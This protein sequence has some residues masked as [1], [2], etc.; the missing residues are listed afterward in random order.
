MLIGLYCL[1]Y[2]PRACT[3]SYREQQS[4]QSEWPVKT[5]IQICDHGNLQ[6]LLHCMLRPHQRR[7]WPYVYWIELN[8]F[9]S[10]M[11]SQRPSGMTRPR[12]HQNGLK[13]ACTN[14]DMPPPKVIVAI[15]NETTDF[16]LAEG[17]VVVWHTVLVLVRRC[18]GETCILTV[19]WHIGF[20]WRIGSTDINEYSTLVL[21]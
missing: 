17:L 19:C 20:L 16:D 1:S 3:F 18:I 10:H 4:N 7:L 6:V 12:T 11:L 8:P 13:E 5:I 21:G 2:Q 9:K 15:M 14:K